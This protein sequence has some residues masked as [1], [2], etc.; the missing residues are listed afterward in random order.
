MYVHRGRRVEEARLNSDGLG[1]SAVKLKLRVGGGIDEEGVV[2]GPGCFCD[3][4]SS[5]VLSALTPDT[6]RF[7][8]RQDGREFLPV[9]SALDNSPA[10]R[11][12][13]MDRWL[14]VGVRCAGVSCLFMLVGG[15]ILLGQASVGYIQLRRMM[16]PS[17]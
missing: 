10:A 6:A 2:S 8:E 3:G 12:R 14:G 1:G 17:A 15:D 13:D 11:R 9:R 7:S 16:L 5:S 4:A